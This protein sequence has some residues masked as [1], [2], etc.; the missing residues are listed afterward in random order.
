MT[1]KSEFKK[2]QTKIFHKILYLK[3]AFVGKLLGFQSEILVQNAKF[4]IRASTSSVNQPYTQLNKNNFC[5]AYENHVYTMQYY[6][7]TATIE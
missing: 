4:A 6:V 3:L 1:I 7:C 5:T 2:L